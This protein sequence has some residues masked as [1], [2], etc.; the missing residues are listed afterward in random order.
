MVTLPD[1]TIMMT[2][3]ASSRRAAGL[4]RA[5]KSV[6][7]QEG[8]RAIPTVVANGTQ[9]DSELMAHLRSRRDIRLFYRDEASRGSALRFARRQ[10]DTE[11]FG[12]L[13]DDDEYLPHSVAIRLRPLEQDHSVDVVVTNGI[14]IKGEDRRISLPN[15]S[16]FQADPLVGLV[17]E[18]WLNSSGGLFRSSG[19]SVEFF[20]AIPNIMEWTYLAFLLALRCRLHFMDEQTFIWN[21]DT[22]SSISKSS[23][24]VRQLPDVYRSLLKFS[25]PLRA[26][27]MIWKKYVRTL[28]LLSSVELD[29]RNYGD[30][31]R[32]HLRSLAHGGVLYLPY[33]RHLLMER[34]GFRSRLPSDEN[35][36]K[37]SGS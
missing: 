33:T 14:L 34:L 12:N 29:E 22:P 5:I 24:Y 2:T 28:H 32:S 1:C 35:A 10:V 6:L 4:L 18:C 11:F 19:V 23:D 37:V 13:D 36:G 20:D 16:R 21:A 17:D 7:E 31:W 26:R 9:I 8:A 30:A 25:M 15:I 27:R 3:V